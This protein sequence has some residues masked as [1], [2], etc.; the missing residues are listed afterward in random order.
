MAV[1]IESNPNNWTPAEIKLMHRA[2]H[3]KAP[4]AVALH[5]TNSAR[6]YQPC[7]SRFS[8]QKRFVDLRS[9][10]KISLEQAKQIVNKYER[11]PQHPLQLTRF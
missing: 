9:G 6:V 5:K 8:P 11:W 10:N 7:G 3:C 2:K 4:I 1:Q